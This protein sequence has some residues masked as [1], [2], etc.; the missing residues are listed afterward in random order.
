M[1]NLGRLIH[2][3]NEASVLNCL[4]IHAALCTDNS[5]SWTLEGIRGSRDEADPDVPVSYEFSS[6]GND[7]DFR[8][9]DF[10]GRILS[11]ASIGKNITSLEIMVGF[12]NSTFAIEAGDVKEQQTAHY[13]DPTRWRLILSHLPHVTKLII[14][15]ILLWCWRALSPQ[16]NNAESLSRYQTPPSLPELKTVVL[17]CDPEYCTRNTAALQYY[18]QYV[19]GGAIQWI[20]KVLQGRHEA[21]YK[22]DKLILKKVKCA[23]QD[24]EIM[25]NY[26]QEI[27]IQVEASV[28]GRG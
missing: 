6:N 2:R 10:L 14:H 4:Y 25:R 11:V 28:R 24:V 18:A 1:D 5:D 21:G 23:E 19:P 27:E 22:L 13:S 12:V 7:D 16:T 9:L 26:V 15:D 3:V 20:H 8:P 17:A